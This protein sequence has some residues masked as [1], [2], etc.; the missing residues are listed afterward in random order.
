MHVMERIEK[1]IIKKKLRKIKTVLK[2]KY[3]IFIYIF[4][5]I[6]FIIILQYTG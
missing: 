2:V 1:K 5:L 4:K 6:V 3:I